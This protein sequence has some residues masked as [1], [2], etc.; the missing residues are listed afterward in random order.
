MTALRK[1]SVALNELFVTLVEE[2]CA[3]LELES[4]RDSN[5]RG[6]QV[7]FLHPNS[8]EIMQALI[9]QGVIGDFRAPST[10]RFGFTPLYVGFEDVWKAASTLADI[11][12]Q[13][14]WAAA[15]Y[16]LRAAVT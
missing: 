2:K 5:E 3:G 16:A 7:S 11:M 12:A 15:R 10:I 8:Y 1:K 13:R 14:A 4:P 6:S 9:E